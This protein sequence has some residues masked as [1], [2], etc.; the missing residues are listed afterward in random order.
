[1]EWGLPAMYTLYDRP[2]SPITRAIA[3]YSF[4]ALCWIATPDSAWA[5]GQKDD[6]L[7]AARQLLSE[8]RL[9]EALSGTMDVF[10]ANKDQQD[11]VLELLTQTMQKSEEFNQTLKRFVDIDFSTEEGISAGKG[12]LGELREIDKAPNSETATMLAL[13]ESRLIFEE[14][15][16]NY[17]A[18]L[19]EVLPLI[20]DRKYYE[21][22]DRY[23]V[24]FT[25]LG[26]STF[27]ATDFR[28]LLAGKLLANT[29]ED[30]LADVAA[31]Q[32]AAREAVARRGD[33]ESA[34]RDVQAAVA[35]DDALALSAAL[36]RLTAALDALDARRDTMA[37]AANR[38]F[39]RHQALFDQEQIYE[40]FLW[41]SYLLIKG[42]R[43]AA[44][45]V[46]ADVPVREGLFQALE[47]QWELVA[48]PVADLIEARSSVLL[49][50]AKADYQ[51]GAYATSREKMATAYGF[52]NDAN[53]LLRMWGTQFRIGAG[54]RP[55]AK[56]LALIGSLAPRMVLLQE[57]AKETR[58]YRSLADLVA[59]LQE[60]PRLDAAVGPGGLDLLAQAR[61]GID[62]R[63]SAARDIAGAWRGVVEGYRVLAEQPVGSAKAAASAEDTLA[64]M[65]REIARF[66]REDTRLAEVQAGIEYAL[67]QTGYD[68]LAVAFGEG[69]AKIAGLEVTL[70]TVDPATGE[71]VTQTRRERYPLQGSAQLET[72]NGELGTLQGALGAYLGRW[73]GE[74]RPSLES[75][76]IQGLL[77]R[78]RALTAA[79]DAVKAEIVAQ[80]LQAAENIRLAAD[81]QRQGEAAYA[82][83]KVDLKAEKFDFARDNVT[84]AG[85]G[86]DASLGY[87][88]D[89]QVRRLRDVELLAFQVE[90]LQAENAIVVRDVRIL[91]T[92]G[93]ALFAQGDYGG[94]SKLYSQAQARWYTTNT[95]PNVEIDLGLRNVRNALLFETQRKIGTD[96]PLYDV[97]SQLYNTAFAAYQEGA[98]LIKAGDKNEGLRRF[99]AAK[100]TIGNIRRL[101]P[102]YQDVRVLAL[103]ISQVEDAARFRTDFD[104]FFREAVA[105]IGGDSLEA[106]S[107]LQDLQQIDPR[108]RGLDDAIYRAR[109]AL[110]LVRP[111]V[112]AQDTATSTALYNQARAVYLTRKT[113]RYPEALKLL[114]QALTLWDANQDAYALKDQIS[115]ELG[116][117]VQL[118]LRND[119]EVKYREA[120]RLYQSKEYFRAKAIIEQLMRDPQAKIYPALIELE[121]RVALETG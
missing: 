5:G 63:R 42:E 16:R 18:L 93:K 56:G 97:V 26:R 87:E 67:L 107:L 100:A 11:A 105:K 60:T 83:A 85:A 46:Q 66:D 51:A 104:A 22:V 35:A 70:A 106:L 119:L 95:L 92:Q 28:K 53:R 78:D 102:F 2:M 57:Q 48:T 38:I 13:L 24:G 40:N 29:R 99:A 101:V 4:L 94:A 41:F 3:V 111:P 62:T 114:D 81:F 72:V 20:G 12:I 54:R 21:A 19:D 80:R 45:E 6:P 30:T 90:I 79:I 65:D 91:L 8:G 84:R 14:T 23:L 77:A 76:A 117:T 113:D 44:G 118:V 120:L 36:A 47:M 27:D 10:V 32:T 103:R 9:N 82:Q 31:V 71:E 61:A 64:L 88:E 73:I 7:V 108:Y 115:A 1:M 116:G 74:A 43:S 96:N 112:K 33:L 110:G 89:T 25:T 75:L 55:T 39:S 86:L 50:A 34:E 98:L 17:L 68:R 15:T 121:R 109:L 59:F 52:L 37:A 69:K 49:A 58:E